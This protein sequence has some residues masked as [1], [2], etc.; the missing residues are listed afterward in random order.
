MMTRLL[1]VDDDQ[2]ILSG[3]RRM[4][5]GL[6]D[7]WQ[8]DFALGGKQALAAMELEA[9]DVI[10]SDM[11]M[12]VVDGAMLLS[13]VQARWPSTVRIVLSGQSEMGRILQATGPA[14]QYLSKPCDPEILRATVTQCCF[15]RD[16]LPNAHL[17]QLVSQQSTVHSEPALLH[18]VIEE[19]RS[20]RGDI[21]RVA[22]LA[23]RDIG[24]SAKIL[25]LV[26]TSFFGQRRRV[27]SVEQAVMLIGLDLMRELVL[28]AKV[29]RPFASPCATELDLAQLNAHCQK[30]ADCSWNIAKGI[31][32]SEQ[33]QGD[34]RIAGMLHDVGKVV[35]A[36]CQPDDYRRALKLAREKQITIWQAEM[37]VFGAS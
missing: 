9:Y 36:S 14:H 33:L 32:D 34:S 21:Q 29:F 28:S 12:P 24:M 10:V 2:N 30:V 1:F 19:L 3:L 17:Q 22:S 15:L 6:R 11:R 13:E 18:H 16:R 8:L 27:M 37:E 31:A 7:D 4:M 35:L 26:S 20:S 23:A 5:R 25:Q